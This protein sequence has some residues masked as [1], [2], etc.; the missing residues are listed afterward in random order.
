[1]RSWM[2]DVN[3]GQKSS[4]N[5]LNHDAGNRSDTWLPVRTLIMNVNVRGIT[6]LDG[7]RGKKQV[8]RPRVRSWV[9]SEEN[10][11]YWRNYLRHC[12]DFSTPEE[13]CP[14]CPPSLRP[15]LISLPGLV[16]IH[17]KNAMT[18]SRARS[19]VFCSECVCCSDDLT[20]L[21]ALWSC[22][23]VKRVKTFPKAPD[24]TYIPTQQVKWK[25]RGCEPLFQ[26]KQLSSLRQRLRCH[27]HA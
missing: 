16:R 9:L 14:L 7:A 20:L 2:S 21:H 11:L 18:L 15:W 25:K 1:M 5:V 24:N 12:Q 23:T 17:K 22:N 19:C 3:I 6:S 4:S 10:V 13:L 8:W 26:P 27:V